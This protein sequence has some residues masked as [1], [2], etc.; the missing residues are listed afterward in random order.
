MI[1]R[2]PAPFAH[3]QSDGENPLHLVERHA[4]RP[5]VRCAAKRP[6]AEDDFW[7]SVECRTDTP[8]CGGAFG[9]GGVFLENLAEVAQLHH[10][11]AEDEIDVLNLQFQI[12][13]A[14]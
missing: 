12:L 14:L 11:T 3:S 13:V 2:R 4:E 1:A 7:G 10:G 6:I 5:H 8:P 9:R